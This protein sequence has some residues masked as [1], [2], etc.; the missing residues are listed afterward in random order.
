MFAFSKLTDIEKLFYQKLAE[1]IC[2]DFKTGSLLDVGCGDGNLLF[3]IRKLAPDLFLTGI[4]LF[5][6]EIKQGKRYLRYLAR[7]KSAGTFEDRFKLMVGNA[8][9][10]EFEPDTFDRVVSTSA[11]HHF[12]DIALVFKEM[13]R[14]LRPGGKTLVYD[15]RKEASYEATKGIMKKWAANKPWILRPLIIHNWMREYWDAYVSHDRLVG[16]AQHSQF[17]SY[18]LET[19]SLQESP[20]FF[21]LVLVK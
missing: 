9:A 12:P 4:D 10:L 5:P 13:Y 1:D 3:Y 18:Q 17:R 11:L 16:L 14:V 20:V 7:N 15:W 2:Q 6:G 8:E 19:F 21:K